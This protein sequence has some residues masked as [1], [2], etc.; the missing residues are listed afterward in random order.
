LAFAP[1][2]GTGVPAPAGLVKKEND[3]SF[4][5]QSVAGGAAAPAPKKNA[6]LEK[7]MSWEG[8][9]KVEVGT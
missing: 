5:L 8:Q 7:V 3:F 6:L 9:G 2:K 4:R 1:P